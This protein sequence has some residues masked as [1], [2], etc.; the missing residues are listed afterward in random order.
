MAKRGLP[1][2]EAGKTIDWNGDED[3]F[4]ARAVEQYDE[5]A[6][7]KAQRPRGLRFTIWHQRLVK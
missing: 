5:E 6:F 4:A 1:K 3:I 7:L 2:D